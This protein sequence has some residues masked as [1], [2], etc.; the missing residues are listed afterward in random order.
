MSK[1]EVFHINRKLDENGIALQVNFVF[2]MPNE[3]DDDFNTDHIF[4]KELYERGCDVFPY[5]YTLNAGTDM[6]ENPD[7]FNITYEYWDLNCI[8]PEINEAIKKCPKYYFCDLTQAEYVRRFKVLKP[9]IVEAMPQS[10]KSTVLEME[11]LEREG[12]I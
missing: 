1:E 10:S 7:E 5:L 12:V 6:Y 8:V 3:T 11:R 4:I 2:C 9:L